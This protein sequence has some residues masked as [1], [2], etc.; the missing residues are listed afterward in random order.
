[1]AQSFNIAELY[2]EQARVRTSFCRPAFLFDLKG[3]FLFYIKHDN[4][5]MND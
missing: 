1:M 5:L 3:A 2:R 4:S